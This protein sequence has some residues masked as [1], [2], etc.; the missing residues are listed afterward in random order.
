[1]IEET[2]PG[3]MVRYEN[4]RIHAGVTDR[5]YNGGTIINYRIPKTGDRTGNPLLWIGAAL[6]GLLGA[7]CALRM[8]RKREGERR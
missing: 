8:V 7:C 1:M 6:L 4:V 2:P 3:F 5:C